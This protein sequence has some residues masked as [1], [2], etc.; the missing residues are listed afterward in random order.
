M[1]VKRVYRLVWHEEFLS[2][3]MV[4]HDIRLERR[5]KSGCTGL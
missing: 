5:S 2:S 3:R 4:T 1:V